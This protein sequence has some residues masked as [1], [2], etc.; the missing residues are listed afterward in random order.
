MTNKLSPKPHILRKVPKSVCSF[1]H[2]KIIASYYTNDKNTK[3][4]SITFG[5]PYSQCITKNFYNIAPII[6]LLLL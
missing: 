5:P 1:T 4:A 2:N 3:N 6:F